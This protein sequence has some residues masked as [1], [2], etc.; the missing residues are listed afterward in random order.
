MAAEKL[1]ER[2]MEMERK[3]REREESWEQEKA[4]L[5]AQ[6][7]ALKREVSRKEKVEVHKW[8]RNDLRKP[9][10]QWKEKAEMSSRNLGE[11]NELKKLDE[12]WERIEDKSTLWWEEGD[13]L[14]EVEAKLVAVR[15]MVE[16]SKEI[17]RGRADLIFDAAVRG[18][19]KPCEDR[20]ITSP[21]GE[22]IKCYTCGKRGHVSTDCPEK[23]KK[24]GTKK[25]VSK[26][27]KRANKY[28]DESE[29][30][31]SSDES[32]DD[33]KKKEKK[34]KKSKKKADMVWSKELEE[35][36]SDVLGVLK[37]RNRL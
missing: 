33:E 13:E 35:S 18:W 20:G 5:M 14:E 12:L 26:K 2:M 23:R 22:G 24:D 30:S 31:E 29:E 28:S 27:G 11:L 32:E 8:V 4:A 17:W 25:P 3:M 36:M 9:M 21:E 6:Q 15:R 34:R 1:E 37:G 19:K 10:S 16:K 7:E